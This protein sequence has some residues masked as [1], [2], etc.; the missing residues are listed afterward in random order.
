MS[1]GGLEVS[2]EDIEGVAKRLSTLQIETGRVIGV[3]AEKNERVSGY[4]LTHEFLNN[5]EK[6]KY[7]NVQTILYKTDEGLKLAEIN[8]NS[9]AESAIKASTLF[10]FKTHGLNWMLLIIS[11]LFVSWTAFYYIRNSPKPSWWLFLLILVIALTI[12]VAPAGNVSINIGPSIS[13]KIDSTLFSLL[14]PVGALYY[15]IARKKIFAKEQM[16]ASNSIT[17]DK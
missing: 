4:V 5:D 2:Q 9:S 3:R 10:D 8:F 13:N 14:I 6:E 15:W 11:S 1:A 12:K 7:V 17:I 16:L